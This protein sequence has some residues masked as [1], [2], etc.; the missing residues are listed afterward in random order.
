[1]IEGC[2][3]KLVERGDAK[4]LVESHGGLRSDA[5]DAEHIE[6]DRRG[7][8]AQFLEIAHRALFDE[9]IDLR[10]EVLA[11][12]GE[13]RER[14]LGRHVLDRTRQPLDRPRAAAVCVDAEDV[15]APKLEDV[16]DFVEEGGDLLIF[17]DVPLRRHRVRWNPFRRADCSIRTAG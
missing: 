13:I 11:D 9:P 3:P 12:A 4:L 15:L 8:R 2:L 1:M 6:K 10:G 7:V 14:A 17:H 5:R 16:G